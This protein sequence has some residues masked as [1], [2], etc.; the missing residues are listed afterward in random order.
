MPTKTF[1]TLYHHTLQ[2]LYLTSP[3]PSMITKTMKTPI[4]V[5]WHKFDK[6]GYHINKREQK[7]ERKRLN[8]MSK[9]HIILTKVP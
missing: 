4:S 3:N 5:N 8:P 1:Y 9:V 2:A 6:T 7:G